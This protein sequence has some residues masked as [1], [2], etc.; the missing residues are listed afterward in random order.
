MCV[1]GKAYSSTMSM[2]WDAEF[3]HADEKTPR[4]SGLTHTC[5]FGCKKWRRRVFLTRSVAI[6]VVVPSPTLE[7]LKQTVFSKETPFSENHETSPIDNNPYRGLQRAIDC[8]VFGNPNR[9]IELPTCVFC[10]RI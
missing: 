1:L 8:V 9:T 4:W 6:A 10:D 3:R 5:A 2:D 7:R